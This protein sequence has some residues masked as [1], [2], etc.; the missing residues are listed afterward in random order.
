MEKKQ[1]LSDLSMLLTEASEHQF[2]S[3]RF[4]S[5]RISGDMCSIPVGELASCYTEWPKKKR[6]SL[7]PLELEH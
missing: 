3:N 4:S 6:S 7:E 1:W 2:R 5:K